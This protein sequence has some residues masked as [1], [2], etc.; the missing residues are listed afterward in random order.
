MQTILKRPRN[1]DWYMLGSWSPTAG[2][3]VTLETASS[4][5]YTKSELLMFTPYASG[6]FQSSVFAPRYSI[7]S[8]NQKLRLS[9]TNSSN[10]FYYIDI[11]QVDGTHFKLTASDNIPGDCQVLC[12]SLAYYGTY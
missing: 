1:L 9:W 8:Y 5:D 11:E 12:F 3:S 2:Q 4:R 7:A 10:V 6:R